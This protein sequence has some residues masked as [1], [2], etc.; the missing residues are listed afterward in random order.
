MKI[1]KKIS[2]S[3]GINVFGTEAANGGVLQEKVLLEI[4]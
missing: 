2:T 3:T 4:S 1:L